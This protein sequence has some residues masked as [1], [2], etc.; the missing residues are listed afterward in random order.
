[1]ILLRGR[2]GEASML[3]DEEK[4]KGKRGRGVRKKKTLLENPKKGE[5]KK[6]RG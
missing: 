2:R 1:V 4:R 6:K 3:P 5:R